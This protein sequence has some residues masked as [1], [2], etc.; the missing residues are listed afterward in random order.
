[1]GIETIV[2]SKSY[3]FYH[4]ECMHIVQGEDS[5]RNYFKNDNL[6]QGESFYTRMN[7]GYYKR[8]LHFKITFLMCIRTSVGQ[9]L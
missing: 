6:M 2:Q 1:M 8:V 5:K 4:S 7:Q 9:L 3:P